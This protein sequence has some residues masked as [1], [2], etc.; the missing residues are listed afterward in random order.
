M[1]LVFCLYPYDNFSYLQEYLMP[2]CI[3]MEKEMQ[4]SHVKVD[5]TG[6]LLIDDT[7]LSSEHK[8][9]PYHDEQSTEQV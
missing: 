6:P 8:M 3:Y 7:F 5:L 9:M 4:S 1:K 2:P